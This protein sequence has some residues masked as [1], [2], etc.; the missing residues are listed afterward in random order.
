[1]SEAGSASTLPADP[2]FGTYAPSTGRL[3]LLQLAQQAP[4]N[5]LGRQLARWIRGIYLWRA[6]LPV[7]VNVGELRLR[8]HLHDNTCERKFVFT[9]WRFDPMELEALSTGL[10][11]DGVFVDVGANV[12]IYVLKAA[13]QL[14]PTGRIVAFEPSPDALARL[15]FNLAATADASRPWPRMDICDHGVSDR[16]EVRE[17]HVDAG[18]LG[19]GSI[20]SG[21]ARFTSAGSRSSL[22]IRCR[23]LLESLLDLGIESIDVLKIDIEG[24][25]DVALMPFLARAADRMLP[26]RLIVENSEKLWKGDLA[27]ALAARD[28]RLTGKSRLNNLYA[29]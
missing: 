16:E 22:R 8:C 2:P 12:G 26:R 10:P 5:F 3:R 29:L 17:L 24:A 7:D 21:Q 23:P 28:Y 6:P 20:L 15:R 4:R 11:D 13:V 27:G 1:V 25:E 18:N 19:G 14:G 9:P